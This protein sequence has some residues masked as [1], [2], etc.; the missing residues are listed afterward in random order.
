ML[1]TENRQENIEVTEEFINSL[2]KNDSRV[3]Q[4][5]AKYKDSVT[6]SRYRFLE[7]YLKSLE[8]LQNG[9]EE[10]TESELL[11]FNELKGQV[12]A[13][14][15]IINFAESYDQYIS[16]I[17]NAYTGEEQISKLEEA[18]SKVLEKILNKK[19]SDT[20]IYLFDTGEII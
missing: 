18:Y 20:L 4:I 5:V 15:G 11:E 14:L 9:L 1:Y 10:L 17:I 7:L 8:N 16:G 13:E 6:S 19:V 12:G 3:M 2:P